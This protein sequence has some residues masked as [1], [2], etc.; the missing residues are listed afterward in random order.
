M[1][2]TFPD[3]LY[4]FCVRN[5]WH[6]AQSRLLAGNTNYQLASQ[7]NFDL[8]NDLLLK[9][10]FSWKDSIDLY[11]AEK[12]ENWHD[13][14]YENTVFKTKDTVRG[15]FEFLGMRDNPE[16]FEKACAVSKDLKHKYYPMKRAFKKSKYKKQ[17]LDL[18][19]EGTKIFPYEQAV[20]SVPGNAWQY[21]FTEVNV[22]PIKKIKTKIIKRIKQIAKKIICF[23]FNLSDRSNTLNVSPVV[24]GAL[25]Q[26]ASTLVVLND[27]RLKDIAVNAKKGDKISFDCL[28]M[29]YYRLKHYK[30]V[31]VMDSKGKPYILLKNIDFLLSN[32]YN[33]LLT[34]EVEYI[35]NYAK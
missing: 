4:I 7:K 1:A 29:Q 11:Q 23:V 24:F 25:S 22:L 14:R 33:H 35:R 19:R 16:Y 6:G 30:K 31:V 3:A 32:R 5:P 8:P 15:V 27:E 28:Q 34:G 13:V 12:N 2:T 21:Y 18:V 10:V 9:S 26:E 20:N 17:I